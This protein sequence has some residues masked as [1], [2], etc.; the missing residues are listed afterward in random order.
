MIN[1]V[2]LL[3]LGLDGVEA[4][5]VIPYLQALEEDILMKTLKIKRQLSAVL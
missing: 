3:N 2:V 4:S 5:D 1:S